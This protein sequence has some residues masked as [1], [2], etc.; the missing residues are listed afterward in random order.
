MKEKDAELQKFVAERDEL[1]KEK[2]AE[3]QKFVAERDE[4]VKEKESEAKL[5]SEEAE[6]TLLQLH[7]V[8]KELEHY[9]LLSRRQAEMLVKSQDLIAKAAKLGLKLIQ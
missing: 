7:Q 1:V 9:F 5:A 8:Q 6:L 3:L 2:D 4:L